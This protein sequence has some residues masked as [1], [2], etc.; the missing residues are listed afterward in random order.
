M[1]DNFSSELL[2]VLSADTSELVDSARKFILDQ[3]LNGKVLQVFPDGKAQIKLEGQTI[4]A[5]P[6]HPLVAGQI[7]TA[8]VEQVTPTTVLRLLETN[9]GDGTTITL[10]TVNRRGN[11]VPIATP[12]SAEQ[13][14]D[15]TTISR[16]FTSQKI[17]LATLSRDLLDQASDPE[18]ASHVSLIQQEPVGEG[19]LLTKSVLQSLNIP[20]GR[21]VSGTVSRVID[22]TT[23]MIQINDKQLPVKVFPQS[24]LSPGDVVTARVEQ[25]ADRYVL[26]VQTQKEA[27]PQL[28]NVEPSMI[29]PYLVARQPFGEMIEN[30]QKLLIDSPV[31]KELKLDPEFLGRIKES[32]SLLFAK[33]NP[34]PDEITLK[35]QVAQ[36]GVN[37][38]AKVR[39]LFAGTP[40][41]TIN[42]GKA[43]LAGDLKGQLLKLGKDVEAAIAKSD[44][45]LPQ[46]PRNHE[47]SAVL[48]SIKQAT[49]NIELN[50]LTNQYAKQEHQ[51]IV[52]QIPYL[53]SSDGKTVKLYVKSGGGDGKKNQDDK[54]TVS[55]VFLLNLTA[56]GHLRVDTQV[57]K[58]QLS[59][60][61][62]ADNQAVTDF[63]QT[64]TEELK[65]R[66]REAGFTADVSCRQQKIEEMQVEEGLTRFLVKD[67]SRL[68]DVKT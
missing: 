31:L 52:L 10:N 45:A 22:N 55:L 66:L 47:V 16:N 3:I 39:R 62:G 6:Q 5:A 36:S 65:A 41:I 35:S 60:K 53:P 48:Q 11:P 44:W 24:A 40:E 38:E 17:D 49:D 8:K 59:I 2:K 29:K 25:I 32:L 30:L 23:I 56:L 21:E 61:I 15:Q 1:I 12:T 34:L 9:L 54:Q 13:K 51:P 63:I 18:T 33:D 7:L 26:V 58:D 42:A 43:S 27:V 37:Y 64:H 4:I 50:Q 67:P 46:N 20:T 28:R 14:G 68:V 57:N 19:E